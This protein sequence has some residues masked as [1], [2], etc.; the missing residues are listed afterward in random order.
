[1]TV[2]AERNVLANA[3]SN[4]GSQLVTDL[5]TNYL[6]STGT[7]FEISHRSLRYGANSG[8]E[9]DRSDS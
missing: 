6:G 8:A 5:L 1:M 3:S 2:D 9:L 7:G 4:L